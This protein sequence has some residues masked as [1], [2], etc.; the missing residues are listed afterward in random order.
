LR[1]VFAGEEVE[2][3]AAFGAGFGEDER[4]VGKVEGGEIVSSAEFGSDGSPVE[5]AGDH[6]VE[7]EPETVVELD[8]DAF[9][10]AVKLADGVAFYLFDG[11]LHGAEE[12]WAGYADVG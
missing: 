7:D 10:D 4:A 6:E 3:G 11:W 1:I 8:G 12:E 9:A 5:A 2:R